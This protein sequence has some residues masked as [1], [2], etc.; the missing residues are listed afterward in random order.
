M[1]ESDTIFGSSAAHL[2][3]V[4][5][6]DDQLVDDFIEK[7]VREGF[8]GAA[9]IV[10]RHGKVLKKTVYGYKVKYDNDENLLPKPQLLTLD[11]MFDL[12]SLT[13]MYATNYALMRLMERGKLNV[14]EPVQKYLKEYCGFT[15]DNEDRGTRLVRDLLNHTAGY[16]PSVEFYN[17]E[18]VGLDLYSQERQKTI[19]IIT[20]KLGFEQSRDDNHLPVY[21]DTDYMLLGLIVERISGMPL[22]QYVHV[23]FY[24]PLGLTHTLFNPLKTSNYQQSDFAATEIRGNTR[25]GTITFPNVDT[26][27]IQGRVHDEKSFYCMDGVSGHAGLFSNLQD[28]SVL[29]QLMVNNGTY[30]ELRF[31]G[32]AVQQRFV[33]PLDRDPSFGLGWRLNWNKSLPWFGL[34]AST[35]AYGHTGWT[36]NCSVIDPKHSLA[37]VLLTNKRHTPCSNGVF[38]GEKYETGKYGKIMT[39]VYESLRLGLDK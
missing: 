15:A 29:C 17:P 1:K 36:G 7:E 24:E 38:E 34:H 13:K 3:V 39:L 26:G 32:E 22:E 20:T 25:G 10:V 2:Y 18:K 12:A 9:L 33:A 6:M 28:M 27:V 19:D 8:P 31:W 30:G 35:E 23:Y 11:T 4:V 14:D 16:E 21:S 5:S 37:I